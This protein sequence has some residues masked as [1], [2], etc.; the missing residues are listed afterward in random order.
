MAAGGGAPRAGETLRAALALMR[1]HPR[2]TM[3]PLAAVQVPLAIAA[4]LVTVLL[5]ATVFAGETYP[6]R[7]L[8][9]ANEGGPFAAFVLLAAVTVVL[10]LVGMG[11]TIV[12]VEAVARGRPVGPREALDPAFTRLGGLVALGGTL[13]VGAAALAALIVGLVAVLGPVAAIVG[14][15]AFSFL[16]LRIALAPQALMLEQAGAF[17]S[18]RRSWGLMRG[19][20][21]RLAIILL[22]VVAVPLILSLLAPAS[23]GPGEAGRAARMAIDAGLQA[24]QTAIAIPFG[25]FASTALTLYYLRIREAAP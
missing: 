10:G 5:Y 4:T 15:A 12:S 22:A 16:A 21:L 3:A 25:A 19:N 14:L 1:D 18:L 9:G 20:M 2:E 13:I 24:L 17:P 8:A 23:P 6:Q 11:A 7:G